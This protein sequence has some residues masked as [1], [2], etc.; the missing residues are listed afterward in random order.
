MSCCFI[1]F[2][3]AL[4][5]KFSEQ[6]ASAAEEARLFREKRKREVD[7]QIKKLKEERRK[8]EAEGKNLRA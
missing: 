6:A 8:K 1:L 3:Q 7:E 5:H 4:E 2:S